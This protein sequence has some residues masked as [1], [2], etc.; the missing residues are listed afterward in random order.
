MTPNP[1]PSIGRVSRL[2]IM[3]LD[4]CVMTCVAVLPLIPLM[5]I[6]MADAF[7]PSPEPESD[8]FSGPFMYL[9]I[10]AFAIYL[11]KDSIGGRSPAKRIGRFQVINNSTGEAAGPIRCMVRNLTTI[12]W[13]LEVIISCFNTSRRLGDFVAGTRLIAYEPAKE[14]TPVK[15]IQ[16]FAA[17]GIAYAIFA[18]VTSAIPLF[19]RL[20]SGE[21]SGFNKVES[22]KLQQHLSK[23]IFYKV[24]FE[25]KV[26]DSVS[27]QPS[28]YIWVYAKLQKNYLAD[29]YSS[30]ELDRK[31]ESEIDKL[32]DHYRGKLQM[33]YANKG[34]MQMRTTTIGGN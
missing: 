1:Y 21:L 24:D 22:A 20:G 12:I 23:N 8:L 4:H 13:P 19:P 14:K 34:S 27:H 16:V 33:R 5:F 31:I 17:P 6:F 30:D 25:V 10:L 15:L 28:R 26:Y 32:Y 18:A 3:L 29:D 9:F 11:C 7:D 2:G